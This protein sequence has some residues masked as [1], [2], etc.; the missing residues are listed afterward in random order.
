MLFVVVKQTLLNICSQILEDFL[1]CYH[2]PSHVKLSAWK[3]F[4]EE[5]IKGSQNAQ[6]HAFLINFLCDVGNKYQNRSRAM[7]YIIDLLQV[8]IA[9]LLSGKW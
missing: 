5:V 7:E 2:V 1:K 8:N 6:S 4:I 3:G 9:D